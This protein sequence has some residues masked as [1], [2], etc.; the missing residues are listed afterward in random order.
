MFDPY[1][2]VM[3]Q[4]GLCLIAAVPHIV[5]IISGV[6]LVQITFIHQSSSCWA[7][8]TAKYANIAP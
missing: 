6:Q 2:I 1:C 5:F 7:E 4:Q 3:Q 8:F